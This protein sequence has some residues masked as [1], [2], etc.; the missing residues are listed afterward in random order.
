M[1]E[2]FTYR[3][4]CFRPQFVLCSK[5]D[6]LIIITI[7]LLASVACR[8]HVVYVFEEDDIYFYNNM[9]Q[10]ICNEIDVYLCMYIAYAGNG[11]VMLITV[12]Q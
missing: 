8:P 2:D 6:I 1:K 12:I 11:I 10:L 5:A 9:L 7:A 3:N 4:A